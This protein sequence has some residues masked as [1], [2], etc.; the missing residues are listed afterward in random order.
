[1]LVGKGLHVFAKLLADTSARASRPIAAIMP[2]P[3]PQARPAPELVA[4]TKKINA[5]CAE[6]GD[7]KGARALIESLILSR[8]LLPTIVTANVLI[9]AYR[10]AQHA[11]GAEAVLSNDMP[12]WGL[13]PD[14]CTFSTI[15]D[16]YGLSGRIPD[17]WRIVDLAEAA[18]TADSRVY[19]ALLRFV[20][21]DAVDGILE[22]VLRNGVV[23]DTAL[24][25]A[26]LTT[27]ANA[28][29]AAIARS[30]VARFMA[31]P[32][33]SSGASVQ[34]RRAPRPDARTHAL[35]LRAHCAAG[36]APTAEALLVE[37]LAH[38]GC[39]AVDASCISTVMNAYVC[40]APAPEMAAAYRVMRLATAHGVSLDV[41]VYNFLIKGYANSRPPQP[42]AAQAVLDDIRI[43][44]LRPSVAS[45]CCVMDAW[46]ETN[47]EEEALQLME[48]CVGDGLVRHT[49]PLYNT[50]IKA[51][52]RCRCKRTRGTCSCDPCGCCSPERGMELV[53]EMCTHGL[54]PDS[55]TLG[56][57]VDAF[58]SAGKL[59]QA[60]TLLESLELRRRP[61]HGG[62]PPSGHA[63]ASG[64]QPSL[65]AFA[66]I[67]R[68]TLRSVTKGPP[69]G[70]PPGGLVGP[71]R[72]WLL[73][74]LDS[75]LRMM[76]A[77]GVAPDEA[78][79]DML[80]SLAELAG[81]PYASGAP[82]AVLHEAVVHARR[83]VEALPACLTDDVGVSDAGPWRPE[84]VG[85][86]CCVEHAIAKQERRK[87]H[88]DPWGPVPASDACSS[89]GGP[90][91]AMGS[92][93]SAAAGPTAPARHTE[94]AWRLQVGGL[95]CEGCCGALRDALSTVAGVSDV[96]VV[97][98]DAGRAEGMA[99]IQGDPT[100]LNASSL[101][102]AS[103]AVG[104]S[105]VVVAAPTA[106]S[107]EPG[108]RCEMEPK[109][110]A[111]LEQCRSMPG[112]ADAKHAQPTDPLDVSERAELEYLRARVAQLEEQLRMAM[113]LR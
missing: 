77:A 47:R 28:G 49:A 5:E 45:V 1:M 35:L 36:D 66:T 55:V 82:A 100:V 65:F 91:S 96:R 2:Q 109:G 86:A 52:S 83:C 57:L 51:S 10:V 29:E 42:E 16:A 15:V 99:T 41:A 17:A 31:S 59:M 84:G 46:C 20:P 67:F 88:A 19:S 87:G 103:R 102:D 101:V 62:D 30:F 79:H 81:V 92:S 93:D 110:P 54:V 108:S 21:V 34:Q 97:I 37:L 75:G 3:R 113:T 68:A 107:A 106:P 18:G 26:A 23:Y 4:A 61:N 60:W 112:D 85:S 111:K 73:E 43:A 8:G 80:R 94:L 32:I 27:L 11:A 40:Q 78:L 56:T 48:R 6:K 58:C 95:H 14:G 105:A 74:Q 70:S 7:V 72:A 12:R 50:L 98:L 76:A 33:G 104:K 22:R 63:A 24:C 53:E 89:S 90:E 69:G 38:R 13:A 9:K 64:C 39:A 44:G 25:N 71:P